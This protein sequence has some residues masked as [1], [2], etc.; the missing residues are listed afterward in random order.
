M[1]K[2]IIAL[3]LTVVLILSFSGCKDNL[4]KSNENA[5][6]TGRVELVYSEAL[7][8]TLPVLNF[9]IP[10]NYV[11]PRYK[12]NYIAAETFD[13]GI[14][15]SKDPNQRD[16]WISLVGASDLLKSK[17]EEY[18]GQEVWFKVIVR[19]LYQGQDQGYMLSDVLS[20]TESLGAI[21]P[22]HRETFSEY[23]IENAYVAY[24]THEMI[25][26]ILNLGN[27]RL[28]LAQYSRNP[29][30]SNV[31]SD[32]LCVR[33][34][35]MNETDKAE[36][37]AVTVYDHSN[38]YALRQGLTTNTSYNSQRFNLFASGIGLSLGEC[39]TLI[40]QHIDNIKV[41]Q[42]IKDNGS[43]ASIP[44]S[45]YKTTDH[46][47]IGYALIQTDETNLDKLVTTEYLYQ[48]SSGFNAELTKEQILKLAED[49]EIKVIYLAL[50]RKKNEIL[51]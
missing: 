6:T 12:G 19:V 20:F 48:I 42:N 13:S 40:E 16:S 45:F 28:M 34:E 44:S 3:L 31:I 23:Q 41:R 14:Y 2:R 50:E 51:W 7:D 9:K 1:L 33:L 37:V 43:L 4:E 47:K 49:E 8:D 5:E 21:V 36:I 15:P 29:K 26:M 30:Y 18:K 38:V 32:G 39:L 46:P 22:I 27:C 35:K 11:K 17:M 25:D 24:L 10:E